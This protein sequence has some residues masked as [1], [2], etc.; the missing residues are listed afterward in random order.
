M[1]SN[2]ML[3]SF[4]VLFSVLRW[5]ASL[6]SLWKMKPCKE[7]EETKGEGREDIEK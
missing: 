5:C 2:V 4:L 3:I 7:K 1:K 6:S